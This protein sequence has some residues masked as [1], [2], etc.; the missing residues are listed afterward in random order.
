MKNLLLKILGVVSVTLGAIGIFIPV[1]PTTP[2]LLLAAWAFL[3]SSDTLYHWLMNHRI[4]G[5]YIRAYV[6][7]KGVSKFHKIFAITTLWLTLILS[8]SL[9]DKIFVQIILAVIGLLVTI[10]LLKLKT[11]T[12]E[13]MKALEAMKKRHRDNK[14]G[15]F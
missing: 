7:F 3:N 12:K 14:K 11:L 6:E 9:I 8:I 5:L 15:D 1:L 2:F 13:E 10:H 4:F